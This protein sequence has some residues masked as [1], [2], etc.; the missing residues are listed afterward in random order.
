[1]QR[2]ALLRTVA[3]SCGVG[4]G[5]SL[6]VSSGSTVAASAAQES[7][8][9]LGSVP[10]HG[11][12]EVVVGDDQETAY[13]ATVDGFAT[14]DVSDPTDPQVL[15]DRRGLLEDVENEDRSFTEILD[16]EVSG[17]RL[18]VP[19]PANYLGSGVFY[20]FLQYDVSDP[21]NPT[22]IGDPVETG[23]HLHNCFHDGDRLYLPRNEV[24]ENRRPNAVEI[25][26]LSGDDPERL[27]EWSLLDHEPRWDDVVNPFLWYLHDV[28]VRDG[29]AVLPFWN[30]GTYLVDVSDPSDPTYVSH[31]SDTSL[32]DQLEITDAE[33]MD[34]YTGL[35]GN[36]HYGALD[37]TGSILAVG[38]E[39]WVT[40]APEADRHGGIDLYNVSDIENPVHAATID[41]PETPN[42]AYEAGQW[43][44]SH[45]FELRDG[46]LYSSWYRGGVKL[47]DISVLEDP[48]E[49]A[50]WRD[51]SVA[52]FWT[53]RVLE[54][55]ETFVAS[56][57]S[58]L[59]NADTEGA[60][61]VFASEPGEQTD[62]PSFEDDTGDPGEDADGNESDTGIDENESDAGDDEND[63]DAG[64]DETA[65]ADAGDEESDSIPGFTAAGAAGVVGGTLALEAWRR[66]R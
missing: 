55:T 33:M 21:A 19:G 27:G 64:D 22:M 58:I 34:Y 5:L 24:G 15:A 9:P 42:G 60:L 62:P 39:A 48:E 35:P 2:R 10:V 26:D 6:G 29:I 7:Y 61:Y 66:H 40:D 20:G 52:A 12:C 47:H 54:P 30:A 41:A 13:L 31:V 63:N 14:V 37:E 44:T 51:P 46:L 43:T 45:N 4:V 25:Y 65:D 50:A 8:E 18:I 16:V 17:D 3:G 36:D 53:A 1:M 56:S 57:T 49:I 32:E 28:T 59:T 23:Y 38:R 11:A